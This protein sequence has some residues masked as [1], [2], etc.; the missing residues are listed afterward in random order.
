MN[1]DMEF[2]CWVNRCLFP[3]DFCEE[4]IELGMPENDARFITIPYRRKPLCILEFYQEV[5]LHNEDN[6]IY[7]D[8][9]LDMMLQKWNELKQRR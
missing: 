5:C 9:W 6:R 1:F 7:V 4:L 3:G 2:L 8:K